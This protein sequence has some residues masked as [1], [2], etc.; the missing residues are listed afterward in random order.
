MFNLESSIAEWRRQM[1]ASGIQ[2]PVPLDELENHLREE[3]Q[4]QM[5]S[6]CDESSAFTLA[7]NKIGQPSIL[8][9]EFSRGRG[10]MG[11]H[12]NS[13]SWEF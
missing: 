11:C 12:K 13:R 3:I 6:D 9:V 4:N 1:L 8:N 2:S 7:V 10:F 5:S